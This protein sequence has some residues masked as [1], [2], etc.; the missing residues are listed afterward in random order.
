M[1]GVAEND[2]SQTTV[3]PL[4]VPSRGHAATPIYVITSNIIARRLCWTN[5]KFLNCV[6]LE[7]YFVFEI[8]KDKKYLQQFS[9]RKKE[10]NMNRFK[11]YTWYIWVQLL[12]FH[13]FKYFFLYGIKWYCTV[14]ILYKLT[15]LSENY[16]SAS[17]R[18]FVCR[19]LVHLA[20][21]F[22]VR[23]PDTSRGNSKSLKNQ[24]NK[25]LKH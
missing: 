20:A 7:K 10:K 16:S 22:A 13:D 18:S 21:S 4:T 14:Y 23:D 6:Y 5:I 17:V 25:H 1:G 3:I 9:T 12:L 2:V 19:R 8:R 15:V 24:V 11:K